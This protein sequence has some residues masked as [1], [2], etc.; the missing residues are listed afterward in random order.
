MYQLSELESMLPQ[1]SE[2]PIESGAYA[3]KENEVDYD[4]KVALE[5]SKSVVSDPIESYSIFVKDD[6]LEES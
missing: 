5:E 3:D 6:A 2:D 1:L 4:V